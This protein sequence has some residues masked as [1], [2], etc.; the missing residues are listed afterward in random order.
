MTAMT[1][2]MPMPGITPN[3]ATPTK[4]TMDSQNSHCWMRKMRRRSVEFEQA[5][6]RGDHDRGEC[7]AGQIL[8]EVGCEYE[9]QRDRDGAHHPGELRLR[10]GRFGD[11]RA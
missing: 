5:D 4:Q 7:A 2:A 9:K 11:G 1:M 10:A 8:Q 3:T 6:G